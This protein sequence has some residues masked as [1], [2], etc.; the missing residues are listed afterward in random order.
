MPKSS[1]FKAPSIALGIGVGSIF[2]V[3][4]KGKHEHSNLNWKEI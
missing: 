2:D 4:W 1:A 3:P